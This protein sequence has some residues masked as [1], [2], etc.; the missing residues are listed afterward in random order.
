M[1]GIEL[2]PDQ[3]LPVMFDSVDAHA[4]FIDVHAAIEA[5]VDLTERVV[6]SVEVAATDSTTGESRTPLEKSNSTPKSTTNTTTTI[7]QVD[8]VDKYLHNTQ[9]S[10]RDYLQ[11]DRQTKVETF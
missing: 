9:E 2:N 10:T 1:I 5:G 7:E 4:E 11:M 6:P 8:S 3:N